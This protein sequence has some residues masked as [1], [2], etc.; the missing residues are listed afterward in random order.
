MRCAFALSFCLNSSAA[1]SS[2][3]AQISPYSIAW[4]APIQLSD[5]LR[6]AYHPKVLTVGEDTVL[7]TWQGDDSV[8]LPVARSLD[9]GTS[10]QRT[11]ILTDSLPIPYGYSNHFISFEQ[12][13]GIFFLEALMPPRLSLKLSHDAGMTWEPI[14]RC[15]GEQLPASA[16]M[17]A[18]TMV[19]TFTLPGGRNKLARSTDAGATWDTTDEELGEWSPPK[20]CLSSGGVLH[21]VHTVQTF[22][23]PEVEYRRSTDLGETWA[24]QN[25]ISA[26]DQ[27]GSDYEALDVS[28]GVIFSAWRD[29]KGGCVTWFGCSIYCNMSKDGGDTFG[30]DTRIDD[31]PAGYEPEVAI[32]GG[33][34]AAVW[35]DDVEF[36]VRGA[37]STDGGENWSQPDII[38]EPDSYVPDVDLSTRAVHLVYGHTSDSGRS[39][40][41]WYRRGHFI[42]DEVAEEKLMPEKMQLE[43]NYPNPFNPTTAIQYGLLED[44]HVSL[45]LYD[46]LGRE[47]ARLVDEFQ[48]A[49]LKS[50]TVDGTQLA[51]GMYFYKLTAGKFT[52]T[53]KMI[54]M[55]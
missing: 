17:W 43:Q 23:A 19:V 2:L 20:A 37:F 24:Q 14:N 6:S 5:S 41:I 10:W 53:K 1:L 52:A 9:G 55:K 15:L 11:D 12:H 33:N 18:D 40:R 21:L 39:F 22:Q 54:L 31:H 16:T 3:V 50:V 45:V 49:G 47:V 51:S 26:I 25:V 7:V 44:S 48:K 34:I 32:H 36:S 42:D 13:V 27:Q 29:I 38:A 8:H 30:F 28:D 4:D 35:S 46:M